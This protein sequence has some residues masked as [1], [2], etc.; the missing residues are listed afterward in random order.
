MTGTCI[1]CGD[2][3][4]AARERC[5]TCYARAL[6]DGVIS[7]ICEPV[8][9]D[10]VDRMRRLKASGLSLNKIARVIGRGVATVHRHVGGGA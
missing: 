1:D 7:V 5:S 4:I 2:D 9:P 8:R 10:E 3:W 6:R